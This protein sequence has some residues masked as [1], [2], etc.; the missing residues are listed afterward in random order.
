MGEYMYICTFFGHKN[1]PDDIEKDLEKAIIDLIKNKNVDRFYVGNQGNFDTMVVRCLNRI[2]TFYPNIRYYIVLAYMPMPRVSME[3]CCANYNDTIFPEE[4]A[5]VLPKFA[6]I[7]RNK[8][9][10]NKSD[11][12]VTY[13]KNNVGGASR[14]KKISEKKGKVIIEI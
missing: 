10:I 14:F 4:L 5:S 9:M 13:V 7:E 2:K 8:W 3:N 6:I 11:Y 1:A 12:V